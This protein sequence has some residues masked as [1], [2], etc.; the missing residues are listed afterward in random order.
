MARGSLEG[1]GTEVT[2]YYDWSGVS[3][4]IRT[5]GLVPLVSAE[6]LE[7]TLTRL[8]SVVSDR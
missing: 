3:D 8:E 1:D 5:S 7:A 6:N 4:E 2:S